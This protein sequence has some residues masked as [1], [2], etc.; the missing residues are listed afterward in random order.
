M[1]LN[2]QSNLH[3]VL[4]KHVRTG[5]IRSI[6]V[7]EGDDTPSGNAI[8]KGYN[9]ITCLLFDTYISNKQ[10]YNFIT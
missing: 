3:G 8:K 9:T 6:F 10:F 7:L 4:V 5:V 2:K 1:E